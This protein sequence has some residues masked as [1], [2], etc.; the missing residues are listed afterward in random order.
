MTRDEALK[1]WTACRQCSRFGNNF[2]PQENDGPLAAKL[3]MDFLAKAE[4]E[5][6]KDLGL[7]PSGQYTAV[8]K[9]TYG[10]SRPGKAE[11]AIYLA[12]R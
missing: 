7:W 1:Q 11:K 4:I 6:V 8:V 2:T 5:E 3:A 10:E 9:V 12:V